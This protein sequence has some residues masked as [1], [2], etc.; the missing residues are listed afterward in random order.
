MR[1]TALSLVVLAA[2]GRPPAHVLDGGLEPVKVLPKPT[3]ADGT[4]EPWSTTAPLPVARANHCAAAVGDFLVVAGGNHK[5]SG[6]PDFVSLDDVLI[7]RVAK[8]GSLGLFTTAGHL[9]SPGINCVLAVSGRTLVL[10]GGLFTDD[11]LDGKAWTAT[12][13]ETG[14]LSPWHE[15]GTMPFGRRALSAGATVWDGGVVLSD[16]RLP[17]EG[18]ETAVVAFAPLSATS[19]GPWT[20]QEYAPV[21]RGQPQGAFTASGGA[22]IAGGYDSTSVLT[23]VVGLELGVGAPAVTTPLPEPRSF[24]AG[25][26]AD[27]FVFV[28]GGRA[29]IFGATPAVTVTSAEADGG[30]L[31]AWREQ[32]PLPQ[33][34]ANHTATVVGDW[35]FVVGGGNGGP[36]VDTVY[37]ARVKHV[38]Q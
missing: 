4:L 22:F 21:F 32:R 9:P 15:V 2:C 5:P 23:E 1:R 37:R 27:D 17:S 7:A 10:L 8:D 31:G 14:A 29:Q 16:S 24:G 6:S 34:R 18:T 33:P 38:V 19:L 11:T 28:I 35:L 12:L 26:A 25:A 30:V 36:G 3:V 20:M 13:D